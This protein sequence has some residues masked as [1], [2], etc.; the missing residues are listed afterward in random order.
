M[1]PGECVTV[2]ASA[3]IITTAAQTIAWLRDCRQQLHAVRTR[4][5]QA[6]LSAGPL[7]DSFSRLDIAL[8]YAISMVSR[9]TTDMLTGEMRFAREPKPPPPSAS[10]Q[11]QPRRKRG[12]PPKRPI[13]PPSPAMP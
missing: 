13:P 4:A 10:Q 3:D 9:T 2:S 8:E 5:A 1:I 6:K 7:S 12:R 11:E